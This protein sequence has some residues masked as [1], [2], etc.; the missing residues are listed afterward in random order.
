M[1]KRTALRDVHR[2]ASGGLVR[3]ILKACL[4]FCESL[5]PNIRIDTH[6]DNTI[7]RHLLEK[8]GFH[9]CGVIHVE[10]ARPGLPIRG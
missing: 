1:A 4:D 2:V 3:G 6:K 5:T 7:M 8:E 10:E 9:E